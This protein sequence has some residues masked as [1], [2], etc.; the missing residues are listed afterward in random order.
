MDAALKSIND[1]YVRVQ[2]YI[3]PGMDFIL[4]V[5]TTFSPEE[6]RDYYEKRAIAVE[7][8]K[9]AHDQLGE[10][11]ES[12]SPEQIIVGYQMGCRLLQRGLSGC[13]ANRFD[14][15][16][17][18]IMSQAIQEGAE[19]AGLIFVQALAD[20]I[21]I[22]AE[23]IILDALKSSIPII[24]ERALAVVEQLNLINAIPQVRVLTTDSHELVSKRAATVLEHITTPE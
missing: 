20:N 17:I 15:S 10:L 2:Q 12:L 1:V 18:P 6:Q 7:D 5:K 11:C 14:R 4:R 24:R 13:M 19:H 3:D 8:Y 23:P 21:G 22:E 16:Y 9:Q